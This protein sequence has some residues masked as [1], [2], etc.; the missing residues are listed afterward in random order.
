MWFVLLLIDFV[1]CISLSGHVEAHLK[2]L[3]Q[4][5]VVIN[6]GEFISHCTET[7]GFYFPNVPSG[8]HLLEVLSNTYS[9]DKVIIIFIIKDQG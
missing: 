5:K 7:G 1:Y 3:N 6:G 9:F 4:I 8:S 2:D